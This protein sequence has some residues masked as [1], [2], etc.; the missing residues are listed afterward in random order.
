MMGVMF[1]SPPRP[2]A[3][4]TAGEK[5]IHTIKRE[6]PIINTRRADYQAISAG[7][8]RMAKLSPMRLGFLGARTS[9]LQLTGVRNNSP[10]RDPP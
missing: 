4:R 6:K 1:S 10:V 2:R 8:A 5:D 9:R 3:A 7:A